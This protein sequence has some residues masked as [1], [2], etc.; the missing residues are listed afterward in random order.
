MF[1]YVISRLLQG[2]LVI[3]LIS[4]ITFTIMRLLP[5]DPVFLLL[6]EGQ[7]QITEE[8]IDAIRAKWGLDLPLH[9]QYLVWVRSMFQGD[10]GVSLVRTGVP[11]RDMIAESVPVTLIL[12]GW[13][14]AISLLIAIPA[15]VIASIRRNSI[16]DYLTTVGSTLGVAVPNFWLGLKL[17]ILFALYLDLLPPFGLRSWQGYILP[18]IV[19]ATEQTAVLA[20]V[21]RGS[22]LEVLN[23]DYI[24]TAVSK[25]LPQRVVVIQHAVRNALLPV[26]SVIGFRIA[27]LLSGTI[28]VETVFAL[29]GVG[30]LLTD[31]VFRLDYQVVQS[32]VVLLSVLV[33]AVNLLTDLVYVLIDPRIRIK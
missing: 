32:L 10:F 18:V 14:L 24:R 16:F 23:E 28:V 17:I 30:R 3:F 31:S 4:V 27:F 8:Q 21:M 22:M 1:Q 5:G 29:P 11:I 6:G 20:R 26:V 15:G 19:L 33:V 9:Q 13:A 2:F 7:I 25:G 12:N